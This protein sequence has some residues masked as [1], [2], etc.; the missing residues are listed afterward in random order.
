MKPGPIVRAEAIFTRYSEALF[1]IAFVAADC[2]LSGWMLTCGTYLAILWVCAPVI[3]A[4]VKT[5]ANEVST[6]LT[7][8]APPNLT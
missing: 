5:P 3:A 6:L 2:F 1:I 8:S 4:L 7:L